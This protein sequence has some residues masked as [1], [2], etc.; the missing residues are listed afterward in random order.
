[1]SG[2]VRTR[3]ATPLGAFVVLAESGGLRWGDFEDTGRLERLLG[4]AGSGPLPAG[5]PFGAGEALAAYFAG[6]VGA[7]GGLPV[8]ARGTVF[9]RSVWRALGDIPPGGTRSY[10]QLA[11]A[12]GHPGAAR[13]AGAANGANPVS[14]VVPCHRVVGADGRLTGYGGG[15]ERKRWLLAHEGADVR[16][17]T[18]SGEEG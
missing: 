9:Q 8:A 17:R 1:M 7:L 4:G 16:G 5:D 6:D 13:A 2:L 12:A 11:A 14:L 10:A 18:T 3:V 15:L